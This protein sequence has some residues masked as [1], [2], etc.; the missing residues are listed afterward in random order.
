MIKTNANLFLFSLSKLQCLSV[1][2]NKL[3]EVPVEIC[4]LTKLSE[5]NFTSNKLSQLPQQLYHCKELTK[6]YIA[7]NKLINLPEVSIQFTDVI[8]N[9]SGSEFCL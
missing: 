8:F 4:H 7:R 3:E 6:L 5:I 9:F 2:D 1:L